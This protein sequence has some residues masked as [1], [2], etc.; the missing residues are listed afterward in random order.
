VSSALD[1]VRPAAD[2][3]RVQLRATLSPDARFISGDRNRLVQIMWN[4]LSN[5][6]KFTP[7]E[8]IVEVTL[9]AAG[10]GVRMT[11]EDTGTGIA[12]EF[13]PHVFDRFR[14]A[15]S[16]STRLH[17]G[18]GLGLAIVR[19]LVELHRGTVRAESDG[20]GTGARFI[21]E[22]PLTV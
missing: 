7:Q 15:D 5:G 6:I 22:L 21:V 18:L 14:Q 17:G 13:L 8:G 10:A 2:A 9:S 1:T 16:S 3:K 19:H 12:P 4:L 11:V 20:P